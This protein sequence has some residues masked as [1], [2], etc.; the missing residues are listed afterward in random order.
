[1][2]S[3]KGRKISLALRGKPKSEEH[4]RK[5]SETRKRLFREGKLVVWNKKPKIKR[6]CKRCNKKFEVKPYRITTAKF[7]TRGCYIKWRVGKNNHFFG[8]HHTKETKRKLSLMFKGRKLRPPLSEE[9]REKMR[10]IGR[11][12]F[13]KGL[14]SKFTMKGKKH[15]IKSKQK[16]RL[17]QKDKAVSEETRKRMSETRK[18]LFREGKLKISKEQ[19]RKIGQ[20]K[21]EFY[22]K[23]PGKHPNYILSRKGHTSYI[24]KKIKTFLEKELRLKEG[25]DFFFNNPDKTE[26]TRRYPDFQF[27]K[28]NIIIEADGEYWHK[29]KEKDRFRDL[30]LSNAG[31]L[32]YHFLGHDIVNNFEM[33][34]ERIDSLLKIVN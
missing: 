1:M 9:T 25:K 3:K 5:L 30:E 22:K 33:V 29:D 18:K 28:L 15:S 26:K 4:K 10:M 7:C 12:R 8:K 32:I 13:L 6:H 21:S 34:K 27:P 16:M 24:E 31:W 23:H 2:K 20:T 14:N 19:K 17:V 11:E